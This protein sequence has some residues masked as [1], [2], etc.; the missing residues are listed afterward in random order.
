[1]GEGLEGDICLWQ[2]GPP[3]NWVDTGGR[4]CCLGRRKLALNLGR[5]GSSRTCRSGC[6]TPLERAQP[7]LPT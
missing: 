4:T 5:D 1:L 6:V 3:C 7:P 2:K